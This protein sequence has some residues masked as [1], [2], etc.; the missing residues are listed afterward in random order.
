MESSMGRTW[1]L[2]PYSTLGHAVMLGSQT[3][4]KGEDEHDDVADSDTEVVADNLVHE[5]LLIGNGVVS[6][7][8]AHLQ[9]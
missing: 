8:D 3:R 5:D 1:I 6:Q 2:R 9:Q 7:Y 4:R